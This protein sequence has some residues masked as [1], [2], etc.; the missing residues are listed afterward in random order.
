MSEAA[1]V[2]TVRT[3]TSA[4]TSSSH[5][6]TSYQTSKTQ[7]TVR[8]L[9][10]DDGQGSF[11]P[12]GT[13][14]YAGKFANVRLVRLDSR[15]EGYNS[16]YEDAK[17]FETTSMSG[18]G[19][20]G[21]N[22]SSSKGGARSDT[23][24]SEELLAASTVTVSY[25]EGFAGAQQHTMSYTPE[26]LTLDLCPY[27]SD[28]IVPGSVRFRWMGHVYEDYDGVLVRDR[29]AS[30]AGTVAGALDYSSGVARIYDY[31]VDGQPTD[32][33]VDSLWTVRQNWTTASIFMRTAAA[34]VKP[35]GFV[36][37]LADATGEQITA[38]AGV[39][40]VI[41]GTHLRGRIDYQSGVV[42][43]QFGDYVLDTS[44]TAAQKAEWWYSAD[45][46]GAVQP[47][48]IWRPW[49][50]DPTTLRYNSVSYFYLPLDADIIG[51]DPVRL[52][53][54]GRVP[55]YRVGSYVVVSH[56]ASV[57][58]AQLSAGQ[59]INC[60]RTRLSRVY[61]IGADGQ[62]I[63]Q[64][65]TPNLDAGTVAI[66]DTTGW[67]QPVR[68]EHRIEEM[69]RVS[70]VQ[71]SGMLTLTKSLS[72]DF[73][74]GSI[75]SSALITAAPGLRARVSHLFDQNTWNNKWQDTVDGQEALASYNDT[76]SP[77][78]VTNTGAVTER[79]ML[80]ILGNGSTFE[81]IGQYVGNLGTGSIN[82]DFAPL[83]P[84]TNAPYFT[85]PA[86]GW[87]MGWSAGNVLRINTVGAMQPLAAIRA[88]QPS[89]AA[90]TD[91]HFELLTR[92]DIDRPPSNP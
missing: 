7:D 26:P 1:A 16:D 30:A 79:W 44:L 39:D 62:L 29:T 37:N 34:P 31:L 48:R 58:P 81:C 17:T 67:V 32:L 38:S 88:V 45:D 6:R 18:S 57:G 4:S 56:S 80:R 28:Y 43:L 71:I 15:T 91:Y 92:G 2:I 49:P 90:G 3:E 20:P 70:D 25:A 41:S 61:L 24:V 60:G 55:I 21:S 76:I 83:N 10:T 12:D 66:Q 54:D 85:L 63:Q 8:H 40:G 86:L 82:A 75:V 64:G 50:V 14:S 77:I 46:I 51:L 89:E 13:I 68:V 52:P 74:A 73:P 72:H 59:T 33:E 42:E 23:T 53:Q 35:S 78:A 5:S 19:D 36:L 11:G 84:N 22:N 27:T 69:A 9:L 47:D 87:G 65:W